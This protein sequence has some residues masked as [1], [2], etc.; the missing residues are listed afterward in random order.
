MQPQ[1]S[2]PEVAESVLLQNARRLEELYQAAE[3]LDRLDLDQETEAIETF[4]SQTPAETLVEAAVQLMLAV[5]LAEC[6]R[7]NASEDPEDLL[8]KIERLTR[9]ALSV[10]VDHAGV[11]LAEYG[12]ERYAPQRTDPFLKI[13]RLN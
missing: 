6:V 9:S 3:K 12:G 7:E 8:R 13:R 11:A 1:K 4:I 5:G 2:R 10:V